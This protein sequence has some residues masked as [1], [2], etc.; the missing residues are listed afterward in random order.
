MRFIV[1]ESSKCLLNFTTRFVKA[2]INEYPEGILKRLSLKATNLPNGIDQIHDSQVFS[3]RFNKENNRHLYS[4]IFVQHF[5]EY[6]VGF[7]RLIHF[8][9]YQ[10]N[11]FSTS[12]VKRDPMV[13]NQAILTGHSTILIRPIKL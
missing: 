13:L 4:G 7:W 11:Y 12:L 2:F 3:F 10:N 6:I 9:D 5:P 1:V 8:E